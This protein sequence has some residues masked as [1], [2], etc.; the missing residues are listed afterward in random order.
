MFNKCRPLTG[1]VSVL[2]SD[3]SSVLLCGAQAVL[4]G[5]TAELAGAGPDLLGNG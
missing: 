5:K 3:R 2:A 4:C 1:E